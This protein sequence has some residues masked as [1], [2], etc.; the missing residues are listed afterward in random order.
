MLSLI[1]AEMIMLA[2]V[3][4]WPAMPPPDSP[5]ETDRIDR[6]EILIDEAIITQQS[7]GPAAPPKP[8]V[9]VPV[10][11]DEIIEEEID[12]PDFDDMFTNIESTGEM[13][14]ASQE[15]KGEIAGSPER[16]PGLVRI[17]EPNTPSAARQANIKAQITVTFLVGTDGSVE[18]LYI[19]EIRLYDGSEYEIVDHI[20]YGLMEATLEAASK[21][22]FTPAR[23]RGEP[24][25]AYVENSFNF[26]F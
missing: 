9:P 17:V 2:V 15:G 26:G 22:R 10:P 6:E 13:G 19:S 24:V 23:D 7:T 18:D 1:L 12:F 4:L 8:Q 11:N 16:S 5:P 20:G 25:R 14:T 21:W 3:L